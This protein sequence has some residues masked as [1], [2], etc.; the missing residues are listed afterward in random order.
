MRHDPEQYVYESY[1]DCV[2][3]L[4]V[5]TPFENTNAVPGFSYKPWTVAE[6]LEAYEKDGELADEGEWL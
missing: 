5:G 3:H 6:V 1:G 4:L 2:N